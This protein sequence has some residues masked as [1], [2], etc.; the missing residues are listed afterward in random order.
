MKRILPPEK[1]KKTL[2]LL[3]KSF[4]LAKSSPSKV[5]LM[6][7]FDVLFL[8]S[9]LALNNLFRYAAGSMKSPA[10]TPSSVAVFIASSLVYSLIILFVYSFFKYII[11]DFTKSLFEKTE[12]SFKKLWRF[13]LL[14]VIIAGIFFVAA[15]ILTFIF[16]NIKG[17]YQIYF[18]VLL[19]SPYWALVGNNVYALFSIPSL[20]SYAIVNMSHSFFY[21]GDSI[22]IALKKSFKITFTRIKSY[23]GAILAVILFAL[24]LWLLFLGS[25]Y[26]I[27][28]IGSKNYVLYLSA[29][30]YFKHASIAIFYIALYSLILLNRISFY[31]ISRE[32]K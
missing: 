10:P 9:A 13:Y 5:G 20:L 22:K 1:S 29:Y 18:F 15:I 8:I 4:R 24:A 31:S 21:E 12:F 7:L 23:R 3:V 6:V 25:G 27:R 32:N 16:A 26:L 28:I 14:N 2:P 17:P 11:L 19:A 30:A